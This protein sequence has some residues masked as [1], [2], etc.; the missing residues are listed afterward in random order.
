MTG[1]QSA[2]PKKTAA[3]SDPSRRTRFE[4]RQ[5]DTAAHESVCVARNGPV[6]P[7]CRCPLIGVDRKCLA[8]GRNGAIDESPEGVSPSGAPRTAREPLDSYG[9]R[10]SAVAM[11]Y[12]QR[13]EIRQLQRAGI[14]TAAAEALLDRMLNKIDGLC[15]E[16]D[17]LKKEQPSP[18]KGRA[19][20]GRRW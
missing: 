3:M 14:P 4:G 10:C 8:D 2:R 13:G 15:A 11:A 16:R 20:G 12:R 5:G 18:F 7:V 9:S 1:P 6:G 19:L 17:R